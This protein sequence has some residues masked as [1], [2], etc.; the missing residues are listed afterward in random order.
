LISFNDRYGS[1]TFVIV[2][3]VKSGR[4]GNEALAFQG[5]QDFS[6]GH[7]LKPAIWL[8]PIPFF[9]KDFGDMSATFIPILPDNN[10]DQ[11]KVALGDGPF[12]DGNGQHS[13]Y[14]SEQDR[15][16]QQKMQRSEKIFMSGIWQRYQPQPNDGL[17]LKI[18]G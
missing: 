9:A 4:K 16:R 6:T 3:A 12:S 11:F 14:I 18:V 10:L 8:N 17:K 2:G 7:V 15:R 1:I 13:H 5:Q